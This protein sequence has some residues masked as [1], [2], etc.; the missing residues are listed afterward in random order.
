[1]QCVLYARVSTDKQ[2][3]KDL[4]IPAQL[5]LMREFAR[6]QDWT[7][8]E[9]FIEPGETATSMT[10]RPVLQAMLQ[11][12]QSGDLAIDTVV[13][14][15]LNRV[16]RNL[17]DYVPLRA[18]LAKHHVRLTYVVEKIDETPSG[19][20]LENIMASIAQFESAN[21]SE[22]TKKGMRQKV[23][24]GGWPHKP[25]RGYV[26]VRGPD[27]KRSRIEIHE[28][29]G[30]LIAEAFKVFATGQFSVDTISAKL[31]GSGVCTAAGKPLP[32]S[33]VHGLLTNP[34]YTGRVRWKDLDIQG[35]HPALVDPGTFAEVQ[36]TIQAR[37][38][39]P[40]RYRTT[41]GFPLKGLAKCARCRGHLTAE[42][43]G[44]FAYYRCS[45]KANRSDAC[46]ARYCSATRAHHDIASILKT[47]QLSRRTAD[48]IAHETTR[49][50]DDRMRAAD[51]RRQDLERRLA[52][53]VQAEAKATDVFLAGDL[54]PSL[55]Q[56]K[57]H[58]LKSARL[59]VEREIQGFTLTRESLVA[60]VAKI[61]DFS[62]SLFDLYEAV[63]G[64]RQSE[65]L[66]AVFSN[67]VLGADGLVG[68][69]LKPPFDDVPGRQSVDSQAQAIIRAA[70]T[71]QTWSLTG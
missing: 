58:G 37:Y 17:D 48:L 44:R 11:R 18:L 22:E 7:I 50:I 42:R 63:S 8:V 5:Q 68:F 19:R 46:D 61:L 62:T 26:M 52:S 15:K 20:L 55:Y 65:L 43:H 28:R 53:I 39:K 38:V 25:P 69:A 49:L 30:P 13:A 60:K 66:T 71:T 23:L 64:A 51:H 2:A 27:E 6:R 16:A 31:A 21:L 12:I 47:I 54:S 33:Y 10:A 70:E 57:A 32:H 4:S 59:R 45:R 9:E 41:V 56:Q 29:E 36:Q 3:Q 67:I 34:F 14:H 40:L 35:Q 1:M 24:T